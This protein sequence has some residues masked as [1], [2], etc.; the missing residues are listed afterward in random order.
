MMAFFTSFM[1][2][3]PHTVSVIKK[4]LKSTDVTFQTQFLL[5]CSVLPDIILLQ[6]K[7][8]FQILE[9][10]FYLTRSWCYAIHRERLKILNRWNPQ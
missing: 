7:L 10:L 8:G 6:Q 4:F 5:D 3:H 1:M 9:D 2:S